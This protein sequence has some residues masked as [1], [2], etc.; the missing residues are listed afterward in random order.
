MSSITNLNDYTLL[1]TT[2]IDKIYFYPI[3]AISNTKI[4]RKKNAVCVL[5]EIEKEKYTP[6]FKMNCTLIDE[7]GK[8]LFNSYSIDL[9]R[10]EPNKYVVITNKKDILHAEVLPK[11]VIDFNSLDYNSFIKILKE[12]P[13]LAKMI[14]ELTS[15]IKRNMESLQSE[16]K[17]VKKIDIPS[18][19]NYYQNITGY[20]ID[21][22]E[23]QITTEDELD[24]S[25]KI[26]KNI[27]KNFEVVLYE[28]SQ[29]K[30]SYL[31]L[32]GLILNKVKSISMKPKSILEPKELKLD[33]NK[34]SLTYKDLD[35]I[36][37]SFMDNLKENQEEDFERNI[38]QERIEY[39]LTTKPNCKEFK[40]FIKVIVAADQYIDQTKRNRTIL[41]ESLKDR[42]VTSL[43]NQTY[44]PLP[45]NQVLLY[46]LLEDNTI[47]FICIISLDKLYTLLE[48]YRC[49][50]VEENK[51]GIALLK[52]LSVMIESKT[53]KPSSKTIE[54]VILILLMINIY[55]YKNVNNN[56]LLFN[57][58]EYILKLDYRRGGFDIKVIHRQTEKQYGHFIKLTEETEKKIASCLDRSEKSFI[59][60]M[61]QI[62]YQNLEACLKNLDI[63][64]N[65]HEISNRG[66]Q[67]K[68]RRTLKKDI[69][70]MNTPLFVLLSILTSTKISS[71]AALPKETPVEEEE[72]EENTKYGLPVE[73]YEYIIRKSNTIT[74]IMLS[75]PIDN[76]QYKKIATL[77]QEFTSSDTTRKKEILLELKEL[78]NEK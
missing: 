19:V 71:P 15:T 39:V 18:P 55:Y 64:I 23:N 70:D 42:I 73:E 38:I 36:L 10:I 65:Y 51:R 77:Y 63:E 72:V 6:L 16:K 46:N 45:R 58:G 1:E 56:A 24:I 74:Q 67:I 21:R 3:Y 12:T 25:T 14:P 20:E 76:I 26:L 61:N 54:V 59:S 62:A 37:K 60:T 8:S 5:F 43:A 75:K 69:F 7:E 47:D 22:L 33:T 13:E 27:K 31:A 32:Y 52:E 44:R 48:T 68:L 11:E 41:E 17:V 49:N 2:D 9:K 53:L 66:I 29:S 30:L 34:V 50:A 35:T 40:N 57:K 28:E 78:C 4:K